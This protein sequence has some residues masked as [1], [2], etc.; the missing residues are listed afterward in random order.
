MSSS[1]APSNTGVANGTPCRSFFALSISSL[2]LSLENLSLKISFPYTFSKRVLRS[3]IDLDFFSHSIAFSKNFFPNQLML[4]LNEFLI[5]VQ[6]SFLM[7]R[8]KDLKQYQQESRLPC[9]AYLRPVLFL[10]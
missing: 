2:F 9:M 1:L 7:E 5:F 8:L 4:H 3:S 6:H 10:I